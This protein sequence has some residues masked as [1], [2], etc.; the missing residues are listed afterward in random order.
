MEENSL[1]DINEEY[2]A[3]I[4]EYLEKVKSRVT[5][6]LLFGSVAR[7]EELPFP[8]SDIDMIVVAKDLP[9]DFFKRAELVRKIE[10]CPSLLQS[11]WMTEEEFIS[12]LKAGAGYLLDAIY[13]GRIIY[14]T[15]FLR[16]I[17]PQAKSE[18]EIQ[19]IRR[20]GRAWVRPVKR[21]KGIA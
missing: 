17:I 13:E 9:S 19:G 7:R 18:L 3:L 16:R 1:K 14:D 10:D 5:G 8:Q 4:K 20:V 21:A 15:G 12:Q 2:A 6:V 11:I